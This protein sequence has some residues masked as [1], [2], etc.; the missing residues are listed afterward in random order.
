MWYKDQ[1][2][3]ITVSRAEL[4]STDSAVDKLRLEK[5]GS[6]LLL[7]SSSLCPQAFLSVVSLYGKHLST[8]AQ[9]I[10]YQCTKFTKSCTPH[11]YIYRL[12]FLARSKELLHI[13]FKKNKKKQQSA[14]ACHVYF[15]VSNCLFCGREKKILKRQWTRSKRKSKDFQSTQ[16]K[17]HKIRLT[18]QPSFADSEFAACHKEG[19]QVLPQSQSKTIPPGSSCTLSDW[20]ASPTWDCVLAD[21][22]HRS[23]GLG[24]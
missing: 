21:F 8:T 24:L 20:H 11:F 9:E 2:I 3:F 14:H 6:S 15:T 12:Y 13:Q 16:E 22:L 4:L 5:L 23:V 1:L 10:H 17:L 19:T 7:F 18:L